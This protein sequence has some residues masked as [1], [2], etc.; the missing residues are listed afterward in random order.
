MKIAPGVYSMGQEEGGQV[1]AYLLES[2]NKLT[3][4][5]TLYDDDGKRV[6]LEIESL[7][8]EPTDLKHIILTHAHKSHVGGVAALKAVS[9]ATVCSHE[10]EVD[11]IAGRRPATRVSLMPRRPFEVYRL[12]LGLA[13]GLGKHQPCEVDQRLKAGDH[14]GPLQVV[15]TPGHTPGSL[16]FWWADRRA[17]FAGDVITT[18]PEVA[19]GWPGLTLNNARNLRS[20]RDL[21]DFGNAE[22]L[23]TGHG[24]PITHDAAATIRALAE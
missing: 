18:W 9:G 5:D 23:C 14:I 8:Y 10:W 11:I 15:E 1:R 7:G 12:Q 17:L 3:L 24:E 20:V 19:A 13:L 4:I 2:G 16:S 21:T 6:L 22:I